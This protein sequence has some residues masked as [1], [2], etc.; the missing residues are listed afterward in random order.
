M[1]AAGERMTYASGEVAAAA[2]T[3]ATKISW[4]DAPPCECL[5]AASGA[6]S[7][8]L[9]WLIIVTWSATSSTSSNLTGWSRRRRVSWAPRLN[10]GRR[11]TERLLTSRQY[12]VHADTI[13]WCESR[14]RGIPRKLG[15]VSAKKGWRSTR[16]SPCST[17][18]ALGWSMTR[19]TQTQN[20]S[21]F[22]G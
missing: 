22:W 2:P 14:S 6:L 13:A 15:R 3:W 1:A 16:P 20:A 21:F 11:Q 19:I 17:T 9:P 8:I 10:P 5:I 12:T 4:S 18:T 7:T